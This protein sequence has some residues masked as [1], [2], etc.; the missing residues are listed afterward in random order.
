M[1]DFLND[2]YLQQLGIKRWTLRNVNTKNLE[3]SSVILGVFSDT[4][5]GDANNLFKNILGG[6]QI[7]ET[8]L[9]VSNDLTALQKTS[10]KI[11]IALGESAANTLLNT[12]LLL[13][14]LRLNQYHYNNIPVF[15]SAHPMTLLLHPK[16]KKEAYQDWLFVKKY[17]T[18]VGLSPN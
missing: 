9:I 3:K 12:K 6:M 18:K 4:H 2:Y 1:S 8:D 7:S 17:I 15:V 11:I 13:N 10:P 14:E 16:Q 5:F